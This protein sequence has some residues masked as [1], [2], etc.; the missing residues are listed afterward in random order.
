MSETSI[1]DTIAVRRHRTRAARSLTT[2]APVLEEL[3]ARLLDR[4]DDTKSTFRTALDLGGR[5]AIAP[6]MRARGMNVISADFTA[7]MAAR[8]GGLP[9]AIDGEALPFAGKTFDL[10]IAHL[11][12]HWIND[13]PGTLIQLRRAL[14][15]GGLFLASMPVLGTLAE[16][17]TAFLEAEHALTG[18]VNPRIS[19]FPDLRD[20]AGLLQRAGFSSPV[21]DVEDIEF[22]Y[23]NPLMLLHELRAAGETNAVQARAKTI[24]PCA[25]FPAA[26][27]ALPQRDGRAI[28]T[29]RL[30]IMTGWGS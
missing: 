18:A 1:F 5:G 19:P 7:A 23:A 11:A 12:L 16:L 21:A 9:V 30:A 8:A 6:A 3:A 10:I 13:L 4:L 15:P 24:P 22:L 27:S 20:C 14:A 29:L 26:L 17:R 28:A 25:L 2:V